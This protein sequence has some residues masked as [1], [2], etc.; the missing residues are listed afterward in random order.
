[1]SDDPHDRAFF[2]QMRGC[3]DNYRKLGDAIHAI[4]GCQRTAF[5]IGCGIGLQTG[6]LREHGWAIVGGE[7]A[8]AAIDMREPG[9]EIVPF[10]LTRMPTRDATRYNCVI[11]TE[12]AEHIP[13]KFADAIVANV[14]ARAADV[15]VWSAAAP[16]QEWHG[17][18][19]LQR[20]AYWLERFAARGWVL[21]AGRTG[22]LR[23]LMLETRAQHWMGKDNFCVLVPKSKYKPIRFVVTSTTYNADRFIG[24]CME[25]VQR[26]TYPNW[27]HHV[28]DADSQD[29]S[30]ARARTCVAGW[31]GSFESRTRLSVNAKGHRMTALQNAWDVWQDTEDNAVIVWLDGDDWLAHD[32]VLEQLAAAYA[33]PSQPWLTYGQF[34]TDAG[35]VGFASPYYPGESVRHSSWRATH[36]KTFRAGLVKRVKRE[37]IL[38][39]AGMVCELAIDRVI[40][41]PLLEMAGP[42]HRFT[43]NISYVYNTKAS[44]W[45]NVSES[46]RQEEL[47]EV[48]RIQNKQPYAEL[49]E[50]PW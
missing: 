28:V 17:H 3:R 32:H 42:H 18:I 12:T 20:P 26:Q 44:W 27:E 35:E 8:P 15:I 7:H 4:V 10:D 37:D 21:D 39:A 14:A 48:H 38:N 33:H 46:A 1:M 34:M 6:R 13:E 31:P 29:E 23:G 43:G 2:E 24:R 47:A 41:Y 40:M 25:S 36:L 16:G 45:A 30:A 11:C 22:A 50:R 5:D 9:V 49:T 19:N